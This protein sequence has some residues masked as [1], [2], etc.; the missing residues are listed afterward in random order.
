M[1]DREVKFSFKQLS[2]K[3]F[4]VV[5]GKDNQDDLLKWCLEF[6]FLNLH[7]CQINY[8]HKQLHLDSC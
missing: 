1:A 2:G 6:P 7:R 3:R 8:H 4:D 5:D